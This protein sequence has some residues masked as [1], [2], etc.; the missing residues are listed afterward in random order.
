MAGL[1]PW[2]KWIDVESLQSLSEHVSAMAGVAICFRL[3]AWLIEWAV[4]EG[5]IQ[6][7]I[8]TIEEVI[9]LGLF[10]WFAY[11]LARLLWKGRVRNG[12]E[13]LIVVA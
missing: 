8:L 9:F 2:T 5:L 1:M 10:V 6:T 12:L 11:Q 4:P 3:I 7:I 13:S